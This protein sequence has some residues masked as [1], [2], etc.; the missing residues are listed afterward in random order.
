MV[1]FTILGFTG[2]EHE[3]EKREEKKEHGEERKA[4]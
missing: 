3:T 2:G 4:E 1:L